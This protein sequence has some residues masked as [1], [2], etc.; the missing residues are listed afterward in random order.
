[1]FAKKVLLISA[2]YDDDA[3]NN[4]TKKPEIIEWYNS[5]KFGVD[6]VDQYC[7]RYNVARN[8]RGYFIV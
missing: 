4:T 8:T 5:T 7:A 2:I 1:M 6:V 3:I